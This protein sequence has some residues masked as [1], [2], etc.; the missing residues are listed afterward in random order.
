MYWLAS[1]DAIYKVPVNIIKVFETAVQYNH[2]GFGIIWT[3]RGI[4]A[5]MRRSR[6]LQAQKNRGFKSSS[7]WLA[8]Y[9]ATALYY[10]AMASYIL[11]YA[12]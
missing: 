11:K 2:E 4:E 5:S 3:K 9:A 10:C 7:L 8:R 1:H 12:R 6:A